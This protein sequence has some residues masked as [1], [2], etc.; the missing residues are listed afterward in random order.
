MAAEN[1]VSQVDTPERWSDVVTYQPRKDGQVQQVRDDGFTESV[2]V[3]RQAWAI[4]RR[5]AADAWQEV[6][7][8]RKSPLFYHMAANLLE[9][10]M[11]AEYVGIWTWRVRRHLRPKVF[12]KL[13]P[14]LLQKYAW[15]LRLTVEELKSL[16]DSPPPVDPP[17]QGTG[18]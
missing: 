17:S 10:G 15:A 5:N 13:P 4:I 7:A 1:R 16:P 14:A 11:L 8:G 18:G 12:Q 6:R 2:H 9:P 3:H